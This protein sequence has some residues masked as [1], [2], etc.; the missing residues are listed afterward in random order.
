MWERWK[1]G[2]SILSISRAL[3]RRNKSGV[4]LI[5]SRHGVITFTN[6]A[7]DEII[8]RV[9]AHPAV[10]PET[11]HGFCWSVL[12]DFQPELGALVSGLPG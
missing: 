5:L 10:R 7:K 8:A 3:D 2:E 1:R 11:I 12:Q 9:Q 4:Q 6:V